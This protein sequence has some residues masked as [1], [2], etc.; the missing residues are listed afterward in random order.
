MFSLNLNTHFCARSGRAFGHAS[1]S[2]KPL[3]PISNRRFPQP[4]HAVARC[5]PNLSGTPPAGRI[6][7]AMKIIVSALQTRR[8]S[9]GRM[10]CAWRKIR[11]GADAAKWYPPPPTK[12]SKTTSGAKSWPFRHLVESAVSRT[13]NPST[14]GRG[15]PGLH[16]E[17]L[18]WRA[19]RKPLAQL[20]KPRCRTQSK[21]DDAPGG[22]GYNWLPCPRIPCG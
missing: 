5:A 15:T 10:P 3:I 11:E 16:R 7:R 12:K 21:K 22:Y 9:A 18:S 4:H 2:D 17:Q 19:A 1:R 20:A 13:C 14:P 8:V 6:M